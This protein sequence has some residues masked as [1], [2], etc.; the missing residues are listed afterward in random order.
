MD[1]FL[2]SMM[3]AEKMHNKKGEAVNARHISFF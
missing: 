3:D 2:Y 1:D